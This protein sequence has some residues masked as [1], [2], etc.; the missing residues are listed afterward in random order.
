MFRGWDSRLVDGYWNLIDDSLDD[1]I[2]FG[3]NLRMEG[4]CSV[5]ALEGNGK[6]R[7][8]LSRGMSR[9]VSLEV[10]AAIVNDF[11][12]EP[13]DSSSIAVCLKIKEKLKLEIYRDEI[14]FFLLALFIPN[15]ILFF[16]LLF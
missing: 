12:M 8:S 13:G 1:R 14:E 3:S 10:G 7:F 2:G 11:G 16:L 9:E 4:C 6:T 15:A 5:E